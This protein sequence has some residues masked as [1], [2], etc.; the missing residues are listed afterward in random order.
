MMRMMW[1]GGLAAA[2]L[3][4]GCGSSFEPGVYADGGVVYTFD[5]EGK[6]TMAGVLA[7]APVPFTYE[8][9]G[10][11]LVLVVA[12]TPTAPFRVLGDGVIERHDGRRLTLQAR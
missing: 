3:L 10:D 7:G 1:F 4:A 5:G 2:L 12:G 6:G 8:A 11:E 9:D